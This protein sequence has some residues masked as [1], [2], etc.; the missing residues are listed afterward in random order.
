MK[1]LMWVSEGQGYLVESDIL[2]AMSFGGHQLA[3]LSVCR[4]YASTGGSLLDIFHR[5][6]HRVLGSLQVGLFT[7]LG[8]GRV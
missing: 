5:I 8:T 1:V 4:G 3:T 6:L 7:R 2:F